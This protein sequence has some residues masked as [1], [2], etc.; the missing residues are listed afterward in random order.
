M[1]KI[2]IY[3]T[4]SLIVLFAINK[5]VV[6][7]DDCL[8]CGGSNTPAT[9]R[10]DPQDPT[11]GGKLSCKEIKT[12]SRSDWCAIS[13]GTTDSYKTIFDVY[14][15]DDNHTKIGSAVSTAVKNWDFLAGRYIG[16]DA[17]EE[18][19][20][21]K[22]GYYQPACAQVRVKCGKKGCKEYGE[23]CPPKCQTTDTETGAATC[24]CKKVTYC[25]EEGIVD[26]KWIYSGKCSGRSDGYT[27]HIEG[28]CTGCTPTKTYDTCRSEALS[29]MNKSVKKVN[30]SYT[31]SRED[32]NDITNNEK[33]G[34]SSYTINHDPVTEDTDKNKKGNDIVKRTYVQRIKYNIKK[35]CLNIKTAQVRYIAFD[36]NCN[37]ADEL[38]VPQIYNNLKEPI[39]QYFIPLNAKQGGSFSYML[40][41]GEHRDE[42]VCLSIINNKDYPY[43]RQT[44]LDRKKKAFSDT[45]TEAQAEK[46]VKGGCYF[47]II[48]KFKVEQKFYNQNKTSFE[49]YTY[50]YR[51]IDVT[52]PFPNGLKD[53]SLWSKVYD[54]T[55]NTIKYKDKAGTKHEVKLNH[56]FRESQL[57][58]TATNVTSNK[59][60]GANKVI[61]TSWNNINKN[62]LS[63]FISDNA[64]ISHGTAYKQKNIYKIGC[65]PANADWSECKK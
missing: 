42:D 21:V 59:V 56:A 57:M 15:N 13:I 44:L 64:F 35:A 5:Q 48:A 27:E 1:R 32:V 61:Y 7:A 8:N 50:Y 9:P 34:V 6:Y 49:G 11:K 16:V 28:D 65:G 39:G 29:A 2:I 36:S 47:A 4:L 54:S 17:Y 53:T 3:I 14:A 25:K 30:A 20:T 33:I 38:T 37:N 60:E 19:K 31:A 55:S 23:Y 24:S 10:V 52:D 18:Y 26:T 51:P 40:E 45:T 62:G 58:Y 46:R 43:W 41:S 12:A 63:S 22:T